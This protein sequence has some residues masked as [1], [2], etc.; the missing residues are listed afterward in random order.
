MYI[1]FLHSNVLYE[2]SVS[3][4]GN[5]ATLKFKEENVPV[6]T[7]GFHVYLDEKMEY[8]IGGDFYRGFTT[9]YRNDEVTEKYNG[10]QLSNDNS[11]YKNPVYTTCFTAGAGGII[12]GETRQDVKTYEE[13]IIP[14]PQAEENY[15]FY[16]WVPEIPLE[17]KITSGQ[18]FTAQF[19]Y[20][21][22]LDEVKESAVT[23]MNAVQQTIIQQGL[24]ITLTDGEVE[25]FTLTDHD[26]TSLMGLQTQVIAGVTQIPWHTSD[27]AEHCKYYSNADMSVITAAAMQFVT[28]HVTY[29]RDLRIYIRSLET[30]EEVEAVTYGVH[31]P[32]DYQSE[33]LKDMY[34]TMQEG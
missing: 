4:N 9:L 11:T 17:G 34:A 33:V 32:E 21:P 7:N 6:N 2:G 24:D 22:T 10:Y 15:E 31:I 14:T 20:I 8:D 28:F 13:L 19:I 29:F 18:T 25:H 30:K 12:V 1:K 26:Q 3:V 27:Q 16:S 23:N 5:V